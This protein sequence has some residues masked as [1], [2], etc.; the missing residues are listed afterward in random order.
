M[1]NT[2]IAKQLIEATK[3]QYTADELNWY[4]E[5]IVKTHNYAAKYGFV[6]LPML[7]YH[8]VEHDGDK[9]II[10]VRP[11]CGMAN[12]SDLFNIKSAW[13]ADD[14]VLMATENPSICIIF[15]TK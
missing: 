4:A 13:G 8:G 12:L 6:E 5:D 3:P 2:K 1:N 9:I 11:K 15:N 10:F 7:D 14:I